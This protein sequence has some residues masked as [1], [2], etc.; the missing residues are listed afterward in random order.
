MARRAQGIL[1]ALS[2]L[3][4]KW[5]TGCRLEE[6]RMVRTCGQTR[7]K[8]HVC[9]KGPVLTKETR[10]AVPIFE[11]FGAALAYAGVGSCKIGIR[12]AVFKIR[13]LQVLVKPA[14]KLAPAG[15]GSTTWTAGG[16]R[17]PRLSPA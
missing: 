11:C 8:Q 6:W 10:G 5:E 15:T 1:A 2:T 14:L 16:A 17:L 9:E 3:R 4:H 7:P 12:W 13:A